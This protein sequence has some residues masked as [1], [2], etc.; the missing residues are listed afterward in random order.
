[1]GFLVRALRGL[2]R[3]MP[4]RWLAWSGDLLDRTQQK[5]AF[6][7]LPVGA[8][9]TQ[10]VAASIKAKDR[11]AD[12]AR[13]FMWTDLRTILADDLVHK[14]DIATMANSIEG[15]SPFLDVPLIEW[16]WSLPDHILFSGRTTK[17][18]LRA[19][20]GRRLPSQ[21]AQAPKRGFEVPVA[22]WLANELRSTVHDALIA[23]D[24]R[25]SEWADRRWLNEVVLHNKGFV[26]NRAQLIWA[27]LMLEIWLRSPAPIAGGTI[28]RR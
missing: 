2:G 8:P 5:R 17:P 3:E 12:T 4:E 1:M 22:R 7:N 16:S 11:R 13:E 24:T 27:L 21:V 23:P 10:P 14:M 26:G 9:T 28:S 25:I 15:R 6:P 20:A 18:L 19:L